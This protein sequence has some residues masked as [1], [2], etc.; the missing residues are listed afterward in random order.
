[1]TVHSLP[2]PRAERERTLSG[3]LK[4]GLILLAC[5]APV[6]ASY[7]SYYVIRPQAR[8]NYGELIQPTRALPTALTLS[9]LDG[10]PVAASS[11]RG[12]WLLVAVGPGAC[13]AA[14]QKRLHLQRQLREMLGREK[15]RL[16]RVW[17]ITDAAELSPPL[18][19][20]FSPAQGG[21]ALRVS[22]ADLQRWLQP[23][24]GRGLQEHLYLVDPMGEWMMRMP[25]EPDPARVRRDLE[26]LLRASASWDRAGR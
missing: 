19:E 21:I 26:R 10:S 2:E 18:R 17:L 5:A 14:C 1:M 12:Q 23:E 20:A 7:F 4:M 11:L 16:D 6:L 3:R 24:P 8:V 25:A 9:A 13:D 22:E 15:D